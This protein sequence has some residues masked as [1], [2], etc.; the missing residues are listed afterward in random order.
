MTDGGKKYYLLFIF[1]KQYNKLCGWNV[2]TIV[3]VKIGATQMW[4]QDKNIKD[5]F[6]L[7]KK[8]LLLELNYLPYYGQ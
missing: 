6:N 4:S 5:Q 2:G 7:G 1:L 8:L 3:E